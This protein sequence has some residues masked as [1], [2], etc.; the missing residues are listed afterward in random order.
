M[1]S[2]SSG[3]DIVERFFLFFALAAIM[4]GRPDPFKQVTILIISVQFNHYW[5][6]GLN[7]NVNDGQQI[8]D[9]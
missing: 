9:P 5:S 7:K 1:V 2:K 4:F 6:L 8:L 3:R